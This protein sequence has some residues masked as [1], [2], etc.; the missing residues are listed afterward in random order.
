MG[1][2]DHFAFE[3]AEDIW[4]EI[5]AVWPAGAG[6]N[7]QRLESAGLQ[8]PC[9]TEDHPGTS[10]LHTDLFTGNNRLR[11]RSI[12]YRPTDEKTSAEFPFCLI[13]GRT[14]YQFNA[15]T[16]TARSKAAQFQACDR[17]QISAEDAGRLG[18]VDGQNVRI[19]SPYGEAKVAATISD[20]VAVGELFATFQ[21]PDLWINM[22]TGPHRDRFVQ[23]PEY[24][25]TAVRIEPI[26]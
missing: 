10:V 13:T 4:N 6:I 24:K 23:T 1:R 2:G 15:G 22:L 16:M 19:I 5:R 8:W 17:L 11:L 25:V 14:L 18:I 26:G 12:D 20:A 21:S 9:P 3:S 7:Y